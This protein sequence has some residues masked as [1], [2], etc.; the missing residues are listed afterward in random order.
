VKEPEDLLR[1]DPSRSATSN[2]LS[3][4]L[5]KRGTGGS[6]GDTGPTRR[7]F[8]LYVEG[9]SDCEILRTWAHLVSPALARAVEHCSVILGGRR[10]ARALEH[11]G[12]VAAQ[13]E[14]ELRALCVLDR[15]GSSEPPW[16]SPEPP[17]FEFYTWPRR[18]IESYLLVPDAIRGCARA[19]RDPR[20]ERLLS[21][22][23]PEP[24]DEQAVR[25]FD[26]K[27]LL[28][29]NG[30]LSRALGASVH[31][32]TVARYMNH[33]DLHDDVLLLLERLREGVGL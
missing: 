1:S 10:P 8:V 2:G 31:P 22:V 11:F 27:K 15:D 20:V 24:G 9:P 5:A 14:L 30:V 4:D 18:H 3:G 12:T 23:M 28:T 32:A 17:G 25:D 16:S 13:S 7:R 29:P 26:A 19:A 21:D 33:S 6:R